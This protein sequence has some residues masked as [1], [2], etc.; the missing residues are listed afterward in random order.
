M[1]TD[2]KQQTKAVLPVL[3]T[4]PSSSMPDLHFYREA[5]DSRI[6]IYVTGVLQDYTAYHFGKHLFSYS[7]PRELMVMETFGPQK[8]RHFFA[9]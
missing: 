3:V 5:R 7:P 8:A 9:S 2:T 1:D 4:P 6:S